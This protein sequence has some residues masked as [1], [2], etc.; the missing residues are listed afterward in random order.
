MQGRS[1]KQQKMIARGSGIEPDSIYDPS[2][3][4]WTP[5]DAALTAPAEVFLNQGVPMTNGRYSPP[6]IGPSAIESHPEGKVEFN[7][8]TRRSE[9]RNAP[10]P[11]KHGDPYAG[12]GGM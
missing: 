2:T 4:T 6:V 7:S 8:P 10:F 12:K 9:S 1:E 11:G 5:L 3:G